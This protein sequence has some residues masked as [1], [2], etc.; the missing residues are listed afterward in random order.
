MRNLLICFLFLSICTSA[1]A[2]TATPNHD[3]KRSLYSIAPIVDKSTQ[4]VVNLLV[5]GE[6]PILIS[7]SDDKIASPD[8]TRKFEGYGSGVIVN[9]KKAYI[10]TNAHIIKHAKKI[11]VTLHDGSKVLAKIIGSDHATDIAVL[12]IPPQ[13][14][15]PLEMGNSDQLKIGDFVAAIGNPFT[16]SVLSSG[17]NQT[18]TFGIVSALN[19]SNVSQGGYYD[20][21]QS[22]VAINPGSSGGALIDM[23][24]KLIGISTALLV[25]HG[26]PTGN[27]GVSF[28]IPINMAKSIMEQLIKYG[29]IKRGSLGV[30]VQNF[31]PELATAFQ[32]NIQK[33]AVISQV[34][35]GSPAEKA[36]LK[37]GDI[38]TNIDGETIQ[39]SS[40]VRN[41][42]GIKRIDSKIDVSFLRDGKKQTFKIKIADLGESDAEVISKNAYLSGLQMQD[43]TEHSPIH[44]LINGIQIRGLKTTT[45]AFTAGL[46]P[47]DII[48]QANHT[49]VKNMA[50]LKATVKT[51]QNDLLLLILRGHTSFYAVL[52]KENAIKVK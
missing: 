37:V 38:L 52:K 39:D 12:E 28:A 21:I 32:V 6:I 33:G 9:A 30:I 17:S 26:A 16:L 34:N 7:D 50:Q 4:S 25:P 43:I 46:K 15:S 45:P 47:G 42:V 36:G 13:K 18:V 3:N 2:K 29:S 44:G 10:L 31:T 22:D 27:I 1:S 41:M 19:R 51:I 35:P 20:F 49:S 11:F 40:Q 48:V 23:D 14:I 5:Q 8:L 24:G